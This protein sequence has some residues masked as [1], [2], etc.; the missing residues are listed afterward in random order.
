MIAALPQ[1]I[2]NHCRFAA[3]S[4]KCGKTTSIILAEDSAKK[5]EDSNILA[6]HVDLPHCRSKRQ[7]H[8]SKICRSKFIEANCGK[9]S[10]KDPG[11]SAYFG[12]IRD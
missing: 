9:N 10:S 3:A 4:Q 8:S 7:I 11:F 2:R 1:K 5:F 12:Q 6:I